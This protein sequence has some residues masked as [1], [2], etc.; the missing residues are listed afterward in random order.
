MINY[1]ILPKERLILI[2]NKRKL[3]VN[4]LKIFR[5]ELRKDPSYS[6]EYDVLNDLRKLEEQY[7]T[8][9]IRQMAL[10]KYPTRKVAI[11][12]P[13][14]I[15][16]GMS[17]MWEMSCDGGSD[18]EVEVFRKS[19]SAIAWLGKETPDILSELDDLAK[20]KDS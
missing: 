10:Q 8:H 13:T 17:R 16:Y 11:I 6:D 20:S 3:S 9:E 7:T 14:N 12:A 19:G 15:S 5:E 4:E 2:V 18:Q 1:K